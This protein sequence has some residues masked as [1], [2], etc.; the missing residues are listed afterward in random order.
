MNSILRSKVL[1]ALFY[2]KNKGMASMKEA[3]TH[4]NMHLMTIEALKT[5]E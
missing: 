2:Q 4:Y 3:Q 5:G 1:I